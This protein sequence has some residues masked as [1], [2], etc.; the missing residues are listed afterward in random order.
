MLLVSAK[1]AI[2]F[3]LKT[4]I[5]YNLCE[6]LPELNGAHLIAR[7]RFIGYQCSCHRL[8]GVVQTT[9]LLF[10]AQS[11]NFSIK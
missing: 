10:T 8:G 1:N 3:H 11:L 6:N 4:I 9:F 2:L 7:S 5:K